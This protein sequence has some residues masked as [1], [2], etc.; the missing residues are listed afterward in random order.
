[1]RLP[2]EVGPRAAFEQRVVADC[3]FRTNVVVLEIRCDHF[4][5][6]IRNVRLAVL[7]FQKTRRVVV[8][9]LLHALVVSGHHES[10]VFD[11]ELLQHHPVSTEGL[12]LTGSVLHFP[13]IALLAL[14]ARLGGVVVVELAFLDERVGHV[15]GVVLEVADSNPPVEDCKGTVFVALVADGCRA[16]AGGFEAVLEIEAFDAHALAGDFVV[17]GLAGHA[18][19]A[20]AVEFYAVAGEDGA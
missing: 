12:M 4:E 5:L 7:H 10:V 6:E 20:C 8:V 18:L 14:F 9:C 11:E 13:H 16:A 17:A 2:V 19:V 3:A 15:R 1:M